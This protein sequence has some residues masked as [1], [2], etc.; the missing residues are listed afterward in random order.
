VRGESPQLMPGTGWQHSACVACCS[1]RHC[2]RSS[3]GVSVAAAV[4]SCPRYRA[5]ILPW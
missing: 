5:Q 1:C 2:A 3:C 4:P